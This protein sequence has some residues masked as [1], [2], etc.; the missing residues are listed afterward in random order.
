M[1]VLEAS[2]KLFLWFSDNDYFNMEENYISICP[3]S[4]TKEKDKIAITLALE[5]LEKGELVASRDDNDLGRCWVLKKPFT[6][7][8]Q[9]VSIAPPI[10]LALAQIVN[11]ACDEFGDDTDR[12]D[13]ASM[14]EKDIRS[15][16]LLYNL[17]LQE[18][19][20]KSLPD[21]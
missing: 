18:L 6:A 15:L 1:T 7:Y 20:N 9:N 3:I 12:C 14:Q 10:A 13:P 19:E 11:A 17:K 2:E 4:E 16:L 8:D 5:D 21:E